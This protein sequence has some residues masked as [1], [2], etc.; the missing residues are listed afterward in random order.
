[1][2]NFILALCLFIGSIVTAQAQDANSLIGT[3]LTEGGRAKVKIEKEGDKYVGTLI[4]VV[5][6]GAL[7]S[8]NPSK[9]E[10]SK[11]LVGKRILKDFVFSKKNV[12]EKGTIYDPDSGK[13][14]SCKI[15][16]QD[17]GS[18]KVRGFIGVSLLGRTSIWTKA[19][20]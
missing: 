11:P 4:W 19:T 15:T 5:R 1:M 16:R 7:D 14:Y 17:D 6:N 2:R 13:T 9:A 18:L 10:Q 8:K 3:Y 20:N 12:W